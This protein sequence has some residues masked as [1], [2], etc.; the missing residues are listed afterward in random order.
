[1]HEY[2]E[3]DGMMEMMPDG[4]EGMTA[5][6]RE[7]IAQAGQDVGKAATDAAVGT[8]MAA[9]NAQ[10]GQMVGAAGQ[11]LSAAGSGFKLEPEAAA[12]LIK[13]CK[14]SLE[15][16]RHMSQRIRYLDR[17]PPLGNTPGAKVVAPFTQQVATGG[18]SGP[19]MLETIK[20][21]QT[22]L[23]QMMQAYEKAST[24]YQETEQDIADAMKKQQG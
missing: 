16:L 1:M 10:S 21:L 4:G 15:D 22:T 5:Q 24:N 18:A 20:N 6:A 14:D 19:G 13:A 23:N 2:G 8:R 3:V 11:M 12:T 7:S 17:T 9:T